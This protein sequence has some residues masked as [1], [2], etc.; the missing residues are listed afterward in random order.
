MTTVLS[1][2][3]IDLTTSEFLEF[4]ASTLDDTDES[5]ALII[6]IGTINEDAFVADS[7][8]NLSGIGNLD[9]EVD[10]NVGVWGNQDDTGLW[11]T[12]CRSEPNASAWPLGDSR[13]NCTNNNGFEDSEDLNRDNM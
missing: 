5:L 4:Y 3:G 8:G 12:G 6:D 11:D 7:L 13:A 1:Q 2:T 9:Q 10:P